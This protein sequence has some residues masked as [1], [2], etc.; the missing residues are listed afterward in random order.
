MD[1]EKRVQEFWRRT[2]AYEKTRKLRAS[3]KEFYF[4][5]GPPYTTGSIHLGQA[6]NKTIKDAVVRWRRM[7][8]FNVRDQP[9][10][11]M[12]G[13]PIE[14]QVEKTL[15]ITNKQ[16]IEE[17]GIERF[18]ATCRQFAQDRDVLQLGLR[19]HRPDNVRH[20][21]VAPAQP[22]RPRAGLLQ[23]DPLAV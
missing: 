8:G 7:Q 22:R 11:D 3:G 16:E 13:L 20:V 15:G 21:P 10:Y 12:H 14:V 2:K 19:A 5:D 4:V 9:G 6:L 18:V 1:L 17:L 23:R